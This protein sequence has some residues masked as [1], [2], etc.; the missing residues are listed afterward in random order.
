LV[1][2]VN[3]GSD[4]GVAEDQF[5][6][7]A[8]TVF[9]AG[10]DGSNLYELWQ[11][12]GGAATEV[13]PPSLH[14]SPSQNYLTGVGGKVFFGGMTAAEGIE[15][16]VTD[17]TTGGTVLVK[18]LTPGSGDSV[19]AY[20]TN[21]NGTVFFTAYT[22]ATGRE[23][24]KTDSDGTAAGTGLVK[25]INPGTTGSYPQKLANVSGKLF[26][27]ANQAGSGVEPWFSEGTSSGTLLIADI[28]PGTANGFDTT[29]AN[30]FTDVDGNAFFSASDGTHGSKPWEIAGSQNIALSVADFNSPSAP[31]FFTHVNDTLFFQAHSDSGVELWALSFSLPAPP[32]GTPVSA[33]ATTITGISQSY[34]FTHQ[35]ETV[36]VHVSAANGLPVTSGFVDITDN[37]QSD[38]VT[39]DGSGDATATFTFDL[40]KNA[41]PK[42]HAV[43]ASYTGGQDSAGGLLQ[44]SEATETAADTTSKYNAQLLIDYFFVLLLEELLTS[45]STPA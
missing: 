38:T 27:A 26:F 20:F 43:T 7:I 12:S 17:G 13:S 22:P 10:T 35:I 15:P 36:S 11:S 2:D 40:F 41:A 4:S 33:T 21:V 30:S 31:G 9:F 14:L 5:A 6:N 37:G 28:N 16:W 29:S 3:P 1:A 32:P 24:F 18:D 42:E 45:G 39:L 8:G 44:A 25:D 19:P 23:L 34:D